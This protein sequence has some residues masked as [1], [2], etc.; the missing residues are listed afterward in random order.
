MA[1][2]RKQIAWNG[3][4][5]SIPLAWEPVVIDSNLLAFDNSGKPAME[6]K[7]AA[8]KGRFSHNAQ[9]K[10]LSAGH[11]AQLKKKITTW[12]LP[13]TWAQ[14]LAAYSSQGFT[15]QSGP[16]SGHGAS[17]YCPD[18]S[19]AIIFQMFDIGRKLTDRKLL[20]FLKTLSDH[21]KDGF[22]AW[23]MFE[24]QALL[25][26]SLQLNHYQFKPGNHEL[27]FKDRSTTV[28]LYRWAPASALLNHSSLKTF[29]ADTL[30][31]SPDQLNHTF[32]QGYP[33]VEM[34]PRGA[35]GWHRQLVRL[36]TKPALKWVIVWHI[37]KSNR[38]LGVSLEGR[39]PFEPNQILQLSQNFRLN[40]SE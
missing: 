6:I 13:S 20:D 16:K 23:N 3:I 38:I 12:P 26:Q 36:G 15:W 9:L 29:A 25:P 27:T 33:A 18:C 17:L 39:K 37:K 1:R 10:R 34:L 22:T 40:I 32:V 5:F 21:R 4:Q 28:R 14:A 2:T 31:L 35:N 11:K 24:I 8:V 19:T 7:W 30:V